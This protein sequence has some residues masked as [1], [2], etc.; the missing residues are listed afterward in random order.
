M[1]DLR[2]NIKKILMDDTLPPDNMSARSATEIAERSR[3]L[4]SNLGSAFGRLIDETMIPLVSRIL[5]VMD[6][7][8]YIDQMQAQAM[9]EQG[10]PTADDGG[11]T[12]EAMQ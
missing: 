5:Y 3:E 8:G 4:A 9:A 10:P 7:A 12:M 1:N 2:M 6:Q 11:A